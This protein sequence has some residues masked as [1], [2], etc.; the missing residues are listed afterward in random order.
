MKNL[1][2]NWKVRN[3]L[4]F[5][6]T[7]LTFLSVSAVFSGLLESN[8]KLWFLLFSTVGI[9]GVSLESAPILKGKKIVSIA[10]LKGVTVFTLVVIILST[11]ILAPDLILKAILL[12]ITGSN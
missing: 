8:G 11:L 6:L 5:F 2:D 3:S 7:I 9:V 1:L 4:Y 12:P 10:E